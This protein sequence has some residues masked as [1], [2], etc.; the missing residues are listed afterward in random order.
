M[1][2]VDYA[3]HVLMTAGMSSQTLREVARAG[4][5][6]SGAGYAEIAAPVFLFLTCFLTLTRLGYEILDLG[7][8]WYF[9]LLQASSVFARVALLI[10]LCRSAREERCFIL[11][12]TT[13]LVLLY[14]VVI[15]PSAALPVHRQP[16]QTRTLN[17]K[18]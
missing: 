13:K 2:A 4:I 8:P 12:M 10:V 6:I 5:D 15:C 7:T 17:P 11:K 3:V 9:W 16:F 14:L 18:P 1:D